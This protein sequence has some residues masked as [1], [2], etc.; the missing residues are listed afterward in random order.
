MTDLITL[1]TFPTTSNAFSAH[2]GPS[3]PVSTNES[4]GSVGKG[5]KRLKVIGEPIKPLTQTFFDPLY[6]SLKRSIRILLTKSSNEKLPLTYEAIYTACRSL[7]VA[8]GKGEGVWE[9]LKMEMEGCVGRLAKELVED[10]RE[11]V[12]WLK[13]FVE[14]CGW[15]EGRVGLLESLLTYLDRVYLTTRN[16]LSNVQTLSKTLFESRIF[17]SPKIVDKLVGGVKSWVE[18]ERNNRLSHPSRSTI[19]SLLTHLLTHNQ[20]LPIFEPAYL[21]MTKDFYEKES[22]GWYDSAQGILNSKESASTFRHATSLRLAEEESRSR[23]LLPEVS[24]VRVRNVVERA[25]MGGREVWLAA[26]ALPA[27]MESKSIE[28]L[29]ELYDLFGRVGALKV[30]C[31]AFREYVLTTVRTIVNDKARDEEMIQRLLDFKAF[32]DRAV[33]EAFADPVVYLSGP[34]SSAQPSSTPFTSTSNAS[35]SNSTDSSTATKKKTNPDY[36]SALHSSFAQAFKSR[37]STPAALIAKYMDRAMRKGQEELSDGEFDKI[38]SG[39]LEL[40]RFVEDR[41][42][43]RVFYHRALAKRLL[44]GRSASNDFERRVLKKLKEEHDAEFGM[45]DHM[46]NDL[47]LS[48]DLMGEYRELAEKSGDEGRMEKVK[49]LNVMVLQRSSW[50]FAA[51]KAD[52]DLPPSMQA[53]L[54]AY[55]LF[56]KTK[57]QGRKLEWDHSLGTATL[58]ATFKNGTKDLSMSLYQAVVL[59][60]FNEEVEIRYE[61]IKERCRMNEEEL[62]RTLQSL[63]LGR[64]RILRK[65]SR[66]AEVKEGDVFVFNEDFT[67]ARTKI[68]INSIQ[69][70]ETAEESKRAQTAI[71]G[72]RK[73]LLDAAIVRIMKAKKQLPFQQLTAATIDAVK[74]HFIPEVGDI[75]KRIGSLVEGEYLTRDE[76]DKNLYVYVA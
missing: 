64:H 46:F 55:S 43:F 33:L 56:Y 23:E 54:T 52:V 17:H 65:R 22:E 35:T 57:H 10:G 7:V 67:D 5:P 72:D 6:V 36:K 14:V 62:K 3:T 73:H 69:V 59:L 38:L 68:H 63:A 11:G 44:L 26:G 39:V 16:D 28:E 30:L 42:V 8:G 4:G 49:M 32:A 45:G 1:L 61:D 34:S 31:A 47:A 13:V 41:D 9:V 58:K 53:D 37:H 21:E 60:M 76:T 29:E 75:K 48:E 71:E 25:L 12:E 40:C 20:Y 15:F 18:W 24:W 70:K 27:S 2:R 74:G 66:G 19:S 51:R 50:P